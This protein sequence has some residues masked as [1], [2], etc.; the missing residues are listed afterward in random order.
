MLAIILSI[1]SVSLALSTK[2]VVNVAIGEEE[3]SFLKS[4][5]PLIVLIIA[6][7]ILQAIN[8]NVAI[9]I[10]GKLMMRLKE[11][12]FRSLLGKDYKSVSSYHSGD[13][14]NRINSDV[15]VVVTGVVDIAP[16]LLS[17]VSRLV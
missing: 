11:N 16:S 6:Q 13:L 3:G 15:N 2:S 7:I 10:T 5:I 4:I 9:R 14:L 8:S 17:F 12:I 1:C